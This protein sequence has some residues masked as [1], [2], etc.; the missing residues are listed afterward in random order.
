MGLD[1][2]TSPRSHATAN[3]GELSAGGRGWFCREDTCNYDHMVFKARF[4]CALQTLIWIV[5]QVQPT[6]GDGLRIATRI[7]IRISVFT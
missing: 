1:G 5:T 4:T 6:S 2:C 7:A 3:T